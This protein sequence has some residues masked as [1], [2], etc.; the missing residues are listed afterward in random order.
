MIIP[1]GGERNVLLPNNGAPEGWLWCDEVSTA[2][3][4]HPE[5]YAVLGLRYTSSSTVVG[6]FQTPNLSSSTFITTGTVSEGVYLQYII[7]T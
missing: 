3:V 6:S 7:K 4:S 2:T 1:Y 5:L